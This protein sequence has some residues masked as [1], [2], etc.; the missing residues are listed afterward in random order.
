[1]ALTLTDTHFTSLPQLPEVLVSLPITVIVQLI[2]A[3]LLGR[4]SSPGVTFTPQIVGSA[5]KGPL[6][7]TGTYTQRTALRKL[8]EIFIF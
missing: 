8:W 4:R 7:K 1:M 2:S 5:G 6:T 3:D